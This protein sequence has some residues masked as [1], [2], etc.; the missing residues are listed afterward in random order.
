ML[1]LQGDKDS[2]YLHPLTYLCA[3][4][5]AGGAIE[6]CRSVVKGHVKNAIAVIRPPGHHAEQSEPS[7][8]CI[9]NNVPI[10]ARVC[11]R[12]FGDRCRKV[13]ILDWDVHHGN[14]VQ[15]AFYDDPN[16]LYISI[17]VHQNGKF[18]PQGPYGDHLHCGEGI[19]LGKNVNIPWPRKD[20][21][22]GDYMAAFQKIVMPIAQEFDPDLVIV[23]AGFDA[24]EGDLLG[25][26]HV[27]PACYGHMTSML[28]SLA[29][30]KIAVC[31]EGGYDLRAIARSA[32]AVT[33]VLMGE[34]P[35]RLAEDALVPSRDGVDTIDLVSRTQSRYWR[36]MYP[37]DI[38]I[39]PNADLRGERLHDVVRRAQAKM[40]L[41]KFHMSA[42]QIIHERS[43]PTFQ[44][45]VLAT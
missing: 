1:E 3:K 30:G 17:H 32:V 15:Q 5:S 27:S 42:L 34:P 13:F 24:A 26:C 44:D 23:S 33:R 40:Y 22:D 20:M 39:R 11:Q 35:D 4:L 28:K 31:L 45:E 41:D 36:C 18:Y 2:I 25:G 7:G 37:K 10:A 16:V 9:F 21:H 8:F 19:G 14:G 6:A 12:E 29:Q 43:S 38:A